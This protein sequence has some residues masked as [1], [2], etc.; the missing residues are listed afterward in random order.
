MMKQ[1]TPYERLTTPLV[2]DHGVL[3]AAGWF[4]QSWP[5]SQWTG[6]D[7]EPGRLVLPL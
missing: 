2:R 6:W 7:P 1:A 3:R 4:G 5:M